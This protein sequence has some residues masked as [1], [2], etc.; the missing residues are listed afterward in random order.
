[1]GCAHER[2]PEQRWAVRVKPEQ[3]W[4]VRMNASP[5]NN[6]PGSRSVSRDGV[7]RSYVT[8]LALVRDGVGART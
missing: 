2:E 5:S 3:R 7:G 6:G 1:M 4:A 8:A